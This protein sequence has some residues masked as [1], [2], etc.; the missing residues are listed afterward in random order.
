[1]VRGG[2]RLE[3]VEIL[4]RWLDPDHRYFKVRCSDGSVSM[5]RH[6]EGSGQWELYCFPPT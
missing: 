6:D 5:L 3:I 4:D 1:M 2:E